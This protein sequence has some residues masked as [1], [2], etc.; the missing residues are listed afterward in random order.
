MSARPSQL[1]HP[2]NAKQVEDL[3]DQLETLFRE[4]NELADI[5]GLATKKGDL[6]AR[7]D[8]GWVRVP[9]PT[10]NGQVLTSDTAETAGMRW[11]E[12]AAGGGGGNGSLR[13]W[14]NGLP[15]GAL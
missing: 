15:Y 4:L 5:L 13:Y 11:A 7:G 12:A 9:Q 10:A 14:F 3:D 1:S 8:T 6:I 2:L